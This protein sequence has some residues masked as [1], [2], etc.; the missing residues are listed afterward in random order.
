MFLLG[1]GPGCAGLHA[2]PSHPCPTALM[3]LPGQ[4]CR[5]AALAT[6]RPA[7]A[8]PGLGHVISQLLCAEGL[9]PLQCVT[10]ASHITSLGLCFSSCKMGIML[11][12][13]LHPTKG[14]LERILNEMR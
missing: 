10:L 5:D 14:L 9:P 8:H 1:P 4:F 12:T 13:L 7:G 11:A 6:G 3:R 2:P